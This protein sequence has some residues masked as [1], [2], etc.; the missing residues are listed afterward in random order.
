MISLKEENKAPV[1]EPKEIE[2]YDISDEGFQ[3][4]FKAVYHV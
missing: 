1:T 2:K 4:I 3:I